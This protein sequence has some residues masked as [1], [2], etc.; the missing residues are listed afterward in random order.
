MTIKGEIAPIMYTTI[1]ILRNIIY[2]AASKGANVHKLCAIA[3]V[4]IDDLNDMSRKVEGIKSITGVWDEVLRATHDNYFGLHLGLTNTSSSHLGLLGYL[5]HHCPTIKDVYLSLQT[6][7]DKISGWVSYEWKQE[8][9]MVILYYTIDPVWLNVSPA[10]ARHAIDVAMGGAISLIKVL[11]GHRINPVRVELATTQPVPVIEYEK[12]YNAKV[13]LRAPF[14]VMVLKKD[15]FD[16][17]VL[18]YDQSLYILFNRLLSDQEQTI[19]KSTSFAGQVKK[20]LARE[21]SAQIPSL[22]V[23][24]SHLNMSDRS[25]QRKLQLE[26]L[27]Y[28]G[29]ALEL[30]KELALNLL[31]HS[32]AKVNAI[33]DVLG[34]AEPSSFRKAFKTWTN[35]TPVQVKKDRVMKAVV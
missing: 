31:E 16:L 7:Q 24:A 27:T 34:Y 17:P 5:M 11:T 33:A 15:V 29:L 20:L 32:D 14:N 19:G 1:A 18:S 21:Y 3:G 23:V 12:V 35:A 9:D 4:D 22:S 8:R 10:T 30:K 2:G 26:G 28:R 25:F 13:L 6:H